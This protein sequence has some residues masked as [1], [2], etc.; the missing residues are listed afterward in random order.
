M[1]AQTDSAETPFHEVVDAVAATAGLPRLR[2]TPLPPGVRREVRAYIGFGPVYPQDVVRLWED[3]A[4]THG[5]RGRW[6][7][8][9][10]VPYPMAERTASDS[11]AAQRRQAAWVD[12]IRKFAS[13]RGCTDLRSR[14]DY[15][16]CT[17]PTARVDW[18]ATLARLDSLGVGRLAR[19]GN[20][21]GEDG[22][23]LVVEY[24][25]AGGYRA[26]SYWSPSAAAVNADERA[27]SEIMEL[28]SGLGGQ[29][30]RH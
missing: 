7:P 12:G 14:D 3:R 15:E 11:A 13:G 8:G 30:G 18:G 25:D 28:L 27:A 2:D 19:P 16:V 9:V 4:G 17:L 20:R 1:T 5:W 21:G 24:R 23:S 6:W 29:T 22:V 26:Y 10:Q